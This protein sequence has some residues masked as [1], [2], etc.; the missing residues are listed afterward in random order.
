MRE[1]H[2]SHRGELCARS[3]WLGAADTGDGEH[4]MSDAR[5]GRYAGQ[6]TCGGAWGSHVAEALKTLWG[7]GN[8]IPCRPQESPMDPE[9]YGWGGGQ[10]AAHAMPSQGDTIHTSDRPRRRVLHSKPGWHR[11]IARGTRHKATEEAVLM[12]GLQVPWALCRGLLS[13]GRPGGAKETGLI[14]GGGREQQRC[15]ARAAGEAGRLVV[16]ETAA[17]LDNSWEWEAVD[18]SAAC[19]GGGVRRVK[20]PSGLQG[21]QD[22]QPSNPSPQRGGRGSRTSRGL[23]P[24]Q[25]HRTV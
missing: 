1:P 19:S 13:G 14:A 3:R 4:V 23:G 25:P 6:D 7:R 20:C 24:A 12:R 2:R 18:H 22:S 8:V 9:G 5:A 16:R 11:A 15:E 17:W 10:P 21:S